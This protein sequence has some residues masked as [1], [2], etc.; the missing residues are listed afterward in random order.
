[1]SNSQF[2]E[3][4]SKVQGDLIFLLLIR[5]RDIAKIAYHLLCTTKSTFQSSQNVLFLYQTVR[6]QKSP[7]KRNNTRNL[8]ENRGERSQKMYRWMNGS[9][10]AVVTFDTITKTENYTK[11]TNR[12]GRFG[13][14]CL[15]CL[16]YSSIVYFLISSYALMLFGYFLLVVIRCYFCFSNFFFGWGREIKGF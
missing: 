3:T 13:S 6:F 7:R 8:P 9:F 14:L 2:G 5:R 12:N 11:M 1:M 16:A 10:K 4:T 15:R